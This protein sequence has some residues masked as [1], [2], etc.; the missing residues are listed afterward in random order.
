MRIILVLCILVVG[1]ISYAADSGYHVIKKLQLGGEGG[2]DLLTVDSEAKRLY[3]SRSTHVMV[4]DLNTE[5]VVG[6]I[7]N[8]PG[9]HGIA[10]AP[11]MN[12]GF[13]SNGKANTSTVFDLK[14]LNP[15]SQVK[16]GTN[17]DGILYDSSTKRVFTFNGGSKDVTVID[18]VSLTVIGTIALGGKP[19]IA[20]AD[21]NGKVYVNIEDTSEIVEINSRNMEI[22]KR[23]FLKPCEEPTGIAYDPE[24][25]RIFSGCHNKVMTVLDAQAEKIIATLPIGEDVDGAG[26][27]STARLAFSS[28]GDGTLTFVRESTPGNFQ[29]VETV[30]TQRGART[31]AIDSKTHKIYLPAATFGPLPAPTPEFPKPRPTVIKDSFVVLVVGQ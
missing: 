20:I 23:F 12:R 5:K 21:G 17:P 13:T 11:E 30:M 15:L 4:I 26:F 31:M 2:W 22:L 1:T 18:A 8:T 24:H 16:T 9:I 3:I 19:E 14:T 27:D 6:D 28:N 7:P 25:H 10:V 29:V